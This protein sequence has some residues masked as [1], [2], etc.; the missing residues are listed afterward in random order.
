MEQLLE[1]RKQLVKQ[2]SDA[3]GEKRMGELTDD[4]EMVKESQ[5]N[6]NSLNIVLN[7]IDAKIA[8]LQK[9]EEARQ[10]QVKMEDIFKE[11]AKNKYPEQY[12][13]FRIV[14]M[15]EEEIEALGNSDIS[16][17]A[18]KR[19]DIEMEKEQLEKRAEELN[20]KLEEINKTIEMLKNNYKQ[21]HNNIIFEEVTNLANQKKNIIGELEVLRW[22]NEELN[23]KLTETNITNDD[24]EN[25]KKSRIAKLEG[26]YEANIDT[27]GLDYINQLKESGKTLAE[28][29][30][31]INEE[32]NK[33]TELR[34]ASQYSKTDKYKA[35]SKLADVFPHNTDNNEVYDESKPT[36]SKDEIDFSINL[37]DNIKPMINN[38]NLGPE[39]SETINKLITKIDT[40]IPFAREYNAYKKAQENRPLLSQQD[41][42]EENAEKQLVNMKKELN[43]LVDILNIQV[44]AKLYA[45]YLEATGDTKIQYNG[46]EMLESILEYRAAEVGYLKAKEEKDK[47]LD[48]LN[49]IGIT[50]EEKSNA[51]LTIER[52]NTIEERYK[53]KKRNKKIA[54]YTTNGDRLT[55]TL[56][57]NVSNKG[58]N[59]S[60]EFLGKDVEG[61]AGSYTE[62]QI[63]RYI[64]HKEYLLNE[65]A[66][67][68]ADSK[69]IKNGLISKQYEKKQSDLENMFS[70]ETILQAKTQIYPNK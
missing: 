23:K 1:Q 48:T 56:L 64:A 10:A 30:E 25:Y 66:R 2:I 4:Q 68:F 11:Q 46:Q 70:E 44:T 38:E 47:A 69:R 15:S 20:I 53:K 12:N 60:V 49:W 42:Y 43:D 7:Q 33:N 52:F 40:F 58:I 62:N 31:K 13:F 21:T 50:D 5:K 67:A 55:L 61:H 22:K 34:K 26:K 36:F 27:R 28:V 37:K 19:E 65:K 24:V 3:E 17:Q 16:D 57:V 54:M 39:I 32:Y 8:E 18:Q 59:E 6:I 41:E 45:D 29:V 51:N 9:E 63:L 14:S 35:C